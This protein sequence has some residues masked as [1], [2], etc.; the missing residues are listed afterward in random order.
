MKQKREAASWI[1]FALALAMCI[2]GAASGEA[3]QVFIKA[4]RICM[5]CIGLG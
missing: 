2:Y 4:A 3:Y 5:E 1:I